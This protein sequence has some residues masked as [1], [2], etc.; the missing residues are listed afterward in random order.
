SYYAN[1]A[2]EL[3]LWLQQGT[4][5]DSTG[6]LLDGFSSAV[7]NARNGK[8]GESAAQFFTMIGNPDLQALKDNAILFLVESRYVTLQ[9]KYTHLHTYL[10]SNP[11]TPMKEKLLWEKAKLSELMTSSANVNTCSASECVNPDDGSGMDLPEP[12][13]PSQI[14]DD[15]ILQYPQ[16]FYAPYARERLNQLSKQNS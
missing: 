7:F 8:P 1:D 5:A 10:A 3:R 6:A 4:S 9:D 11:I 2:L 16:G 13:L 15:L 12:D 14:Y